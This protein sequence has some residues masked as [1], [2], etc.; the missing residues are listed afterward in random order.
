MAINYLAQ[1]G[2]LE[3]LIWSIMNDAETEAHVDRLITA[4]NRDMEH[5]QDVQAQDEIQD[6]IDEWNE[7]LENVRDT[8][9]DKTFLALTVS[10]KKATKKQDD[11]ASCVFKHQLL[12]MA[13]MRDHVAALKSANEAEDLI[14][15][16]SRTYF[17]TAN[18][19]AFAIAKFLGLDVESCM[20]CLFE[21]NKIETRGVI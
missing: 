20:A 10:E 8:R 15:F 19:S 3:D 9:Y 7:F 12:A 21:K 5:E 16:A 14:D 2:A 6:E 17:K 1:T 13:E 11:K 18:N 4:L